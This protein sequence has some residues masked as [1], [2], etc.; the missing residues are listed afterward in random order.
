MN[1]RYDWRLG[2]VRSV[3]TGGQV[4]YDTALSRF[5]LADDGEG[6]PYDPLLGVRVGTNVNLFDELAPSDLVLTV[7]SSTSIK[8]DWTNNSE[9]AEGV[10]I[11]RSADGVTYIEIAT[12]AVNTATYTNTG[13]TA[14]TGYYYRIRAYKSTTYSDYSAVSSEITLTA[15]Y[16][17]VYTAFTEKP[18]SSVKSA[19]NSMVKSLVDGGV[20]AK[21]DTL[22]IFSGHTNNNSESLID[23]ILPSRIATLKQEGTLGLPTFTA[24]EGFKGTAD[25]G[26]NN[27]GGYIELG[28]NPSVDKVKY[29]LNSASVGFY[30]RTLDTAGQSGEPLQAT[31]NSGAYYLSIS[32][33]R[34]TSFQRSCINSA[35]D[36]TNKTGYTVGLASIVR[37]SDT[38]V[39]DW[40]NTTDKGTKTISSS[41]IP[42]AKINVIGVPFARKTTHQVAMAYA[43]E[44]LNSI[45]ISLLFNAFETYQRSNGKSLFQTDEPNLYSKL[46][47]TFGDSITAQGSNI[48][49]W[50]WL[51]NQT[52]GTT[53]NNMG[54][55]ARNLMDILSQERIESVTSADYIIISGGNDGTIGTITDTQPTTLYGALNNAISYYKTNLPSA[56]IILVTPPDRL[57]EEV[58][59]DNQS[60]IYRNVY[61]ATSGIYLCD[62]HTLCGLDQSNI[63]ANTIDGVHLNA[64]GNLIYHNTLVNWLNTN[65]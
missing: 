17:A 33:K 30:Y 19:Q 18:S 26:A 39:R 62:L 8:L 29:S 65:F 51:M 52:Y 28:Y 25:G 16:Q 5:R 64:A 34:V 63:A 40:L 13:L 36:S 41:G 7:L 4:I 44:S 43:G 24:F 3:D 37:E 56:K 38:Q 50:V 35:P 23:W 61:A 57:G 55:G 31:S 20:M 48:N 1:R 6:T 54:W 11:E 42:D 10:S 9:N 60:D 21:L 32:P 12:V 15:E 14:N 53:I 46:F 22:H 27:Y 45:D 2:K 59:M 47:V 58:R 49:G